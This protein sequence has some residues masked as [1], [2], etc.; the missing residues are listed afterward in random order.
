[1][2]LPAD[3]PKGLYIF[4]PQKRLFDVVVGTAATALT[5][6]PEMAGAA[7]LKRE[8]DSGDIYI[9][10][11]RLGT[12][13]VKLRTMLNVPPNEMITS[14]WQSSNLEDPRVLP[15]FPA[16]ARSVRF[17]ELPQLRQAAGHAL[18]RWGNKPR[19]SLVGI[20]P[21][22]DRHADEY[23]EHVRPKN[24]KLAEEWRDKWLPIAPRGVIGPAAVEFMG[25][26]SNE[27]LDPEAWMRLEVDY[28][29]N[30]DMNTDIALIG[31]AAHGAASLA[32]AAV[33]DKFRGNAS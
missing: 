5:I 25:R 17:D 29:E 27:A 24:P 1:M 22:I 18:T 9:T 10:Q 16:F 8:L 31:K 14:V 3:V 23:A 20:R 12:K 19:M 26:K 21:L 4:S 11:K 28:C 7:L 15:G 32:M 13:I 2:K 6:L 30:A 33:L